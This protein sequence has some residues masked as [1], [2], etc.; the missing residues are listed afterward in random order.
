MGVGFSF[1][2]GYGPT[3]DLNQV[4]RGR[5]GVERC[6][7]S[8]MRFGKLSAARCRG[9]VVLAY[10]RGRHVDGAVDRSREAGCRRDHVGD[11]EGLLVRAVYAARM[12]SAGDKSL[13]GANLL[14]R[15]Q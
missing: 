12:V 6:Q 2:T 7:N 1:I 5:D 10:T 3:G 14:G 15:G 4:H 11:R 8:V 9:E 13:R